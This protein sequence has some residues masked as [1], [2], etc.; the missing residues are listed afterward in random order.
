MSRHWMIALIAM[1]GC[2]PKGGLEVPTP[3][4]REELSSPKYSADELRI[5]AIE[6]AVQETSRERHRCWEIAA[7]HN[8][9]V[10]GQVLLAIQFANASQ[11]RS[12][13]VVRE[14]VRSSVLT[15]CLTQLYRTYSWPSV[16]ARDVGFQ[17]PFSF[18]APNAQYTVAERDVRRWA[19]KRRIL[20]SSGEIVGHRVLDGDNSGNEMV[21][22]SLFEL[23]IG[24]NL[25]FFSPSQGEFVL[26]IVAGKGTVR[27]CA[28]RTVTP[29]QV[30]YLPQGGD[31]LAASTMAASRVLLAWFPKRAAG[32]A[33]VIQVADQVPK[34]RCPDSKKFRGLSRSIE[35]IPALTIAGGKGRV[36]IVLD[37]QSVPEGTISV[38]VV[39]FA[40][41]SIVPTHSHVG[42]SEV[43]W[44]LDG[45]GK[46]MVKGTEYPVQAGHLIQIPP[47]VEHGFAA[48]G[49]QRVRAL[50]FYTPGG[51]EQRF[52]AGTSMQ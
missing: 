19:P 31:F 12:V 1:L 27:A 40:P 18:V 7:A 45:A 6:K 9:R 41:G 3:P 16:F 4:A 2:G 32:V 44:M 20:G 37:K 24:Q 30:V 25:R 8:Y 28:Q 33:P 36:R 15:D 17:L 22:I 46:L 39:S 49:A 34:K 11:V 38:G 51:P 10:Q 48:T 50:Q 42:S 47:G 52:R 21:R 29:G 14:D 43:L 23:G 5:A 35:D 13:D 26:Y